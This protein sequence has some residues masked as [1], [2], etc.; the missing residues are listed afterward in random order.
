M[1]QVF[2]GFSFV[3]IGAR[4]YYLQIYK[5][6]ELKDKATVQRRQHNSLVHRGEITDRHGLP[7]AI[8]TTRY[9]VYVH[10][11]LV[12]ASTEEAAET[13]SRITHQGNQYEHMLKLLSTGYPVVTIARGLEREA[14]D[15]LQALDW[16]GIDIVP[17]PFR[18]YPEGQL[19]AH[20]LGYVNMDTHGQGGVE[21]GQEQSLKDTGD[22]ATPQLDGHGHTIMVPQAEPVWDITPPLGRQIELTIDNYLQHLAE[23]ELSAMCLHTHA[24]KGAA[25]VLD[26]TSGEILAWANFPSYD[27]NNYSKYPFE[28]TKN[29]SMVDVYQPGSTFKILTVSSGLETGAIKPNIVLYDA[30]VLKV[31]NR[32]VH[33]HDGGHGSIDLLHLFIH[34]SNV[35]AA[36][37]ALRMTPKQFHDQLYA[38]G[39][40]RQTG[41]DLPGESAGLLLD[42]KYWKPM[43]QA[44]TGFGQGAMAVTPLQ[45]AAAVGAVANEG[46]WVEPHLIRRVYDPVTGV[47]GNG[48]NPRNERCWVSRPPSWFPRFW[49]TILH[50]ARKSPD[51]YPAI[52]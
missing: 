36:Q 10:P 11:E 33:N 13:L 3:A 19:A 24:H 50:S 5:G 40:G 35:G 42:A 4:L 39:V 46:V 15:E 6:P 31:G 44:T 32:S 20:L 26:P 8:D 2:I 17:R 21:Q 37:V 38:F 28:V 16:T 29:W 45:L 49:R 18:H 43:D 22:I 9:D 1:W 12:K 52:A 47:T 41:I 27:P 7:L 48:P 30:G 25:L 23:K 14:V 34:S 51:K